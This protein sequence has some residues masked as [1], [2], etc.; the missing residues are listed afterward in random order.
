[1]VFPEA[2][3][4]FC[5]VGAM[6]RH[7]RELQLGDPGPSE[8]SLSQHVLKQCAR[9]SLNGKGGCCIRVVAAGACSVD[10]LHSV[11]D[12]VCLHSWYGGGND[13]RCANIWLPFGGS[14]SLSS[15]IKVISSGLCQVRGGGFAISLRLRQENKYANMDPAPGI[16]KYT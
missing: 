7:R 1:M 12:T 2:D 5:F 16:S 13:C 6:L 10:W 4:S 15:S 9:Y 8:I 14:L 11:P 3:R